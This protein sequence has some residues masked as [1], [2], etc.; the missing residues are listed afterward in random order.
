MRIFGRKVILSSPECFDV[1]IF[2]ECNS[3]II[4]NVINNKHSVG[5]FNMRPEEI[6]ISIEVATRFI[7][8]I[9]K[10]NYEWSTI[11]L[12]NF[13]KQNYLIYIKTC[14]EIMQPKV[15]ITFIDNSSTFSWISKNC[16]NF[17]SIAIQNGFRT[18]SQLTKDVDFYL[19]HYFCFGG[20]E[21]SKFNKMGFTVDNYYPVGSLS[22]SLGFGKI[23][24]IQDE[25]DIL[26]VSCW[27]WRSN[28]A[29]KVE[30]DN[31]IK[32]MKIMDGLLA[33][34][35]KENKLKAAVIYRSVR[36][37]EHWINLDTMESEEDYYKNIYGETIEY[38]E[39]NNSVRNI[40]LTL[41]QSNVIVSYFSTALLEAYGIGKKVIFCNFSGTNIHHEDID[42][43]LVLTNSEYVSFSEKIGNLFSI[44]KEK[45]KKDNLDTMKKY[46]NFTH[47]KTVESEVGYK[48]DDIIKRAV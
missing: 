21:I 19:Q 33:R 30:Q 10:S 42:S 11:S 48:V 7:N 45:Y 38:I 41:K 35:I 36:N 24:E 9:L 20:H 46:M 44:S 6:F 39:T 40:F 5:I 28:P 16:N 31:M 13:L 8:N 15:L 1:V 29:V 37:S 18:S 17:E 26:I 14:I 4:L 27:K 22:A 2:D 25:Y 43:K 34:Y 32:S 23:N 47:N 3:D 12:R